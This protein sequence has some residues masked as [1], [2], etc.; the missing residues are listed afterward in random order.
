MAVPVERL[1]PFLVLK[2]HTACIAPHFSSHTMGAPWGRVGLIFPRSVR[3]KVRLRV[4]RVRLNSMTFQESDGGEAVT[5][6]SFRSLRFYWLFL[7]YRKIDPFASPGASVLAK[8]TYI[9]HPDA[10]SGIGEA[11]FRLA[12]CF[13]HFTKVRSAATQ[14]VPH[15][16][17]SPPAWQP[18]ADSV[19]QS[20]YSM[21]QGCRFLARSLS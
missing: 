15:G 7:T 14:Q 9:S 2:A 17:L 1:A 4:G 13:F 12:S 5:F 10:E 6:L 20:G 3:Q 21:Q 8:K 19:P 16:Y 11:A 18:S